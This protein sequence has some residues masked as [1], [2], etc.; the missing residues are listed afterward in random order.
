M[1]AVLFTAVTIHF[2]STL[3]FRWME[4]LHRPPLT[5]CQLINE[6]CHFF[7]LLFCILLLIFFISCIMY[8]YI[9]V[10]GLPLFS[11]QYR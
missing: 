4:L 8:T 11:T 6:I 1:Q 7:N 5:I 2:N 9:W 10:V 3:Y